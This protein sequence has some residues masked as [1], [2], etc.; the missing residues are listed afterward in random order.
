MFKYAK[1]LWSDCVKAIGKLAEWVHSLSTTPTDSPQNVF[2]QA[3]LHTY[4]E[5]TYSS[6]IHTLNYQINRL[7]TKVFHSIHLAYNYNY[8][9]INKRS[10]GLSQ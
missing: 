6:L 5:A 8:I 1:S 9:Y 4:L 7:K 2:N 3:T 10:K